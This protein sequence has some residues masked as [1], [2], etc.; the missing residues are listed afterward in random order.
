MFEYHFANTSLDRR[1]MRILEKQYADRDYLVPMLWGE[2]CLECSAP[3]CYSTCQRFK[4]RKDGHCRRFEEGIKPVIFKETVSASV[5]FMP[6]AKMEAKFQPFSISARDL[7]SIYKKIIRWGRFCASMSNIIPSNFLKSKWAA[8]FNNYFSR[9]IR[10]SHSNRSDH[11]RLEG[12]IYNKGPEAAVFVDFMKIDRTLVE[13]TKILLQEGENP[14]CI[15]IAR[16]DITQLIN[17]HPAGAEDSLSLVFVSWEIV[18]YKKLPSSP[19]GKKVKCVIW[20]LDDTLWQGVLVENEH[21]TLR[22][23]LAQL[24]ISLDKKGIVNSIASKNDETQAM[25]RLEEFQLADYFVFKKINWD[26]KS[27]NIQKTIREM[28]INPDTVV[29]VDDNPFEREEVKRAIPAITCI[30]PHEVVQYATTARF[31]VPVSEESQKRRS[32]Y[33]MLEKFKKEEDSWDGSIDDF[34]IFCQIKLTLSHPTENHLPRCFELLQ[35][36]NQLNA[37]GRRLTLPEVQDI[38][39]S[40]L[41]DSYVLQSE[42]RFGDYGIVGFLIV[43]KEP[44]VSIT[45]FV[46]SC[47]VANKKI[48]PTLINYLAGK[49][50]GSILFD[51]KNTGL[52]GPMKR[53]IDDLK[54]E[55]ISS[56]DSHQIYRHRH[57][58]YPLIVELTDYTI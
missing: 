21:L 24:I 26:P 49:Y 28:N 3:Q 17:I 13:R 38:V 6:W 58:D 33:K 44:E 23:S 41:Y 9:L 10:R 30:S 1:M 20:D 35:R 7:F 25:N 16:P 54:M 51:Y 47:R 40:P 42:D 56:E 37:S 19:E 52:N 36:T 15:P 5:S 48:E 18:P 53:V 32:T 27:I 34:L 31:D 8:L 22:Q 29:F 57:M 4:P 45:D 12:N 46:I 55:L 39:L 43:R 14:I 11:F 50:G 2:H